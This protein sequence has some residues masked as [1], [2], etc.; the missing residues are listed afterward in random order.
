MSDDGSGS[1]TEPGD[2][3]RDRPIAVALENRLMSHGIYVTAFA[4]TD[5]TAANDEATAVDGAGFELEYETVAEIPAVTSDEV[6]AVLRTLLSIA[7]ERE[8]TPGRLEAMSLT[9]DGTVR[10]RWH[11]E[12]EWFDRLGAELSEAEFSERVLNT[13]RDRPTDRDNR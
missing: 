7:E 10:G 3:E 11:V 13:I 5:E 9:T 8:W 4:W 12:R 2:E 1:K 6:G